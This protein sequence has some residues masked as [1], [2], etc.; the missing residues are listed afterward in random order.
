MK[1]RS[2]FVS[3]SSSSCFILGFNKKL[4]NNEKEKWIKSVIPASLMKNRTLW[5][6][7]GFFSED[8]TLSKDDY[9]K[10]LDE[11]KKAYADHIILNN[12]MGNIMFPDEL[13]EVNKDNFETYQTLIKKEFYDRPW[14]NENDIRRLE[15]KYIN[16]TFDEFFQNV[17]S[18]IEENIA[19]LERKVKIMDKHGYKFV[20]EL[21]LSDFGDGVNIALQPDE[22]ELIPLRDIYEQ[23]KKEFFKHIIERTCA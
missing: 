15:E 5:K 8:F 13:E 21:C 17:S 16:V 23:F 7:F 19:E 3:N 6:E 2:G 20:Y 11:T 4:S 14:Y 9:H 22:D 10:L 12:G 18:D 1:Y